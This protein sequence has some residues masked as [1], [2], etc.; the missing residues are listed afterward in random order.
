MVGRRIGAGTESASFV[1]DFFAL[2]MRRAW[3]PAR[4]YHLWGIN[5]SAI[6]FK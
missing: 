2:I 6:S 5:G 3:D 4:E 1:R